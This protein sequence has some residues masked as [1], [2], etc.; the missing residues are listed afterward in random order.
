M[1][2]E[3]IACG[4]C[5]LGCLVAAR[6]MRAEVA[7]DTPKPVV[8]A[9]YYPWYDKPRLRKQGKWSQAMRLHLKAPQ[10]P[11][12]G[13]YDSR[14]PKVISE[15]IQ[16]SLRAGISFWAVS[17][18]GPG[19]G[20]DEVFRKSI[21]KHPEASKLKYAALYESQGRLGGLQNPNYKRWIGDL[22]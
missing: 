16:Q 14:D 2:S 6:A 18:W 13:L 1:K 11:M 19:S 12:A 20:T 15:H 7:K 21:L 9:Y 22:E 8:G 3:L 17:W 5:V 10:T 4:L